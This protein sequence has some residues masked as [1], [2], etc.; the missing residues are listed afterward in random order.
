MAYILKKSPIN[1]L[2]LG[3]QYENPAL[4]CN[5]IIR[6]YD[7]FKNEYPEIQE[8]SPLPSIIENKDTPAQL[9]ILNNFTSRKHFISKNKDH[10]MQVQTDRIL[11]N[12]RK[13]N[14]SDTYPR[15]DKVYSFFSEIINKINKNIKN[16]PSYNQYELSYIDHIFL[17]EFELSNYELNS[18]LNIIKTNHTYRNIT[19]E[20]SIPREN[21]GGVLS[22]SI[23]SAIRK[24]DKEKLFVL[25]M[26]CRGFSPVNIEKWFSIAHENLLNYFSEIMTDKAKSVWKF[27]PENS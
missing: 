23:K 14:N 26:T 11:F 16:K 6:I 24:D 7:L 19:L 22:V 3:V 27:E 17:Q 4:D 21:I 12:W 10:L 18:I 1:E 9:K 2:I 5:D 15:F 25:E 8:L 13:E 20:Y